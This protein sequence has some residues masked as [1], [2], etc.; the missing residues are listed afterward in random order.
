MARLNANITA[1]KLLRE[2]EKNP[3]K[4]TDEEKQALANVI[5]R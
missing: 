2:I 3:R 5:R 4:L 1:I